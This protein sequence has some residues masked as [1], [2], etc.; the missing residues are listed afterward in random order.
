MVTPNAPTDVSSTNGKPVKCRTRLVADNP[1]DEDSFGPHQKIADAIYDLIQDEPGGVAIGIEGDWGAGK[2]TV[3]RLLEAKLAKNGSQRQTLITFNA[4]AHEGDPL[5]RTFLESLIQHLMIKKSWV[6]EKKWKE[7]LEFIGRKKEQKTTINKPH[8]TPLGKIMGFSLILIP[9]GT[10]L[11]GTA[12]RQEP[13]LSLHPEFHLTI[14]FVFGLLFTLGP[15]W[16]YLF[17]KLAPLRLRDWFVPKKNLE[18][19]K[20]NFPI[21]HLLLNRTIVTDESTTTTKTPDPT[22]IEFEEKFTTLMSEALANDSVMESHQRRIVLVLDNL[23][24]VAV[25]D[26]LSIWSTLQTFLKQRQIDD[27]KWSERVWIIVPYDRNGLSL[28]WK[29]DSAGA[30]ET[31]ASF[32]DKSFQVRFE[33]P[34][35]VRSEW[36]SFLD[37]KLKQALPDH[38]K[39]KSEL[40]TVYRVMAIYLA[41]QNRIPTIRELKLFV[42]QIGSIHRQ[43]CPTIPLTHIAYFVMLRRPTPISVEGENIAE[44]LLNGRITYLT[45]AGA[46]DTRSFPEED[47]L[48]LLDET[49]EV[50]RD[51]LA[52]L[53][54]NVSVDVARQLLLK[55]PI[56]N[57]LNLE[58]IDNLETGNEA[59]EKSLQELRDKEKFRGFWEVLESIINDEWTK[60]E[61]DK[62]ARA[63]YALKESG[64]IEGA[65]ADLAPSVVRAL[66]NTASKVNKWPPLNP[67]KSAG[68]GALFSLV[69]DATYTG[70]IL[71]KVMKQLVDSQADPPTLTV[72]SW[73]SELRSIQSTLDSLNQGDAFKKGIFD[74]LGAGIRQKEFLSNQSHITHLEAL[75]EFS[76]SDRVA[77]SILDELIRKG[78]L[79]RQLE[80]QPPREPNNIAWTLFAILRNDPEQLAQLPVGK[81]W[82]DNP[83]IDSSIAPE[84][85]Q[86]ILRFD[87]FN[88]LIKL[89]QSNKEFKGLVNAVLR[90][91]PLNEITGEGIPTKLKIDAE[92]VIDNWMLFETDWLARNVDSND[93]ARGSNFLVERT[94]LLDGIAKLEFKQERLP[95]YHKLY[96]WGG[97]N[98]RLSSIISEKLEL[99]T[100]EVW[101]DQLLTNGPLL[102]VGL[103]T[104]TTEDDVPISSGPNLRIG[105]L[106]YAREVAQGH[107][108]S[109]LPNVYSRIL[110]RKTAT[111]LAFRNDLVQVMLNSGAATAPEFYNLFAQD[112]Y[113]TSALAESSE[114]AMSFFKDLLSARN[115]RG[116]EWLSGIADF[117]WLN[118]T[119][120]ND[121]TSEVLTA[122]STVKDDAAFPFLISLA[123]KLNVNDFGDTQVRSMVVD[124]VDRKA[125]QY[126]LIVRRFMSL[127][128]VDAL[129]I[130]T[131]AKDSSNYYTLESFI[132]PP[133]DLDKIEEQ[134]QPI[135]LDLAKLRDSKLDDEANEQLLRRFEQVLQTLINELVTLSMRVEP[136]KS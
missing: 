48:E 90:G 132:D 49:P 108:P 54:F 81:G 1:S 56:L 103:S 51:N 121:L 5:R 66:K 23:D 13:R 135:K 8:L 7:Q 3:V 67:I 30:G 124:D 20:G 58:G 115:A 131:R 72:K 4:W 34:E 74:V 15:F 112:L 43:W 129:R 102:S 77:K 33:V 46:P 79:Q 12:L 70:F 60:G 111:R 96:E 47:I 105:M 88:S 122:I 94:D 109:I 106:D 71:P 118:S 99:V 41:R 37:A 136:P 84:L 19:D 83:W 126:Q 76:V 75:T 91:L 9:L 95:I 38:A 40:H 45:Q 39:N 128:N 62:V 61:G 44:A 101:R 50:I 92:F 97:K 27:S 6:D 25:S 32:M 31:A 116:L 100:P 73:V 87:E 69:N 11:L 17:F 2:S 42:N 14:Y 65:T 134:F 21:E 10:T 52:A 133:A 57:M 119:Q 16:L 53:S 78:D 35:P 123:D 85:V 29:N 86:L 80:S 117:T 130:L 64:V 68:I 63:A 93:S 110:G 36:R 113:D 89:L 98:A 59:R 114:R 18:D 82:P 26:A 125:A 107:V 104:L 24:R 28:L 127:P 22:A 55:D 120:L